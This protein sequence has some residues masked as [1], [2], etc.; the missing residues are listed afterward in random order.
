MFK[1]EFFPIKLTGGTLVE[2]KGC[3]NDKDNV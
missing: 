3:I 1:R 2:Q